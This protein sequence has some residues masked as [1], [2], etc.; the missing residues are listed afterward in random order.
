MSE[1]TTLFSIIN[2]KVSSVIHPQ[3]LQLINIY[4]IQYINT[5]DRVKDGCF[6][7]IVNTLIALIL[8]ALYYGAIEV[9]NFI[10]SKF[11]SEEYEELIHK[12]LSQNIL[13]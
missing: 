11:Y 13:I 12:K 2:G 1:E 10:T 3:I 9:Y 8:S 6:T 4:L 7:I 5:G